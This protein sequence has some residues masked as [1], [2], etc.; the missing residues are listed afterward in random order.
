MQQTEKLVDAAEMI[1]RHLK[2][3]RALQGKAVQAL[4]MLEPSALHARD[5]LAWIG[6]SI[7]M[8]R[9][10]LGEATARLAADVDFATLTDAQL[11]RIAN[12]EH[13]NSVLGR[14]PN[15]HEFT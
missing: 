13:I 8:E 9:L 14:F 4:Q 12:G 7:Q 2:R 6:Q 5:V 1:A 3:A 15:G 10:A 11:L